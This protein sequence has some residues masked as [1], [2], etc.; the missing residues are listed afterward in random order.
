MSIR[1]LS[2]L[3]LHESR[4]SYNAFCIFGLT[5]DTSSLAL[6]KTWFYPHS[7]HLW[8]DSSSQLNKSNSAGE[9]SW[10]LCAQIL[11][12]CWEVA[13]IVASP[14]NR[15]ILQPPSPW[16]WLDPLIGLGRT[17]WISTKT[18]NL[19]LKL[20]L[21]VLIYCRKVKKPLCDLAQVSGTAVAVPCF[22]W[23]PACCSQSVLVAD[24]HFWWVPLF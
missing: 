5:E 1:R 4:F 22:C 13:K 6:G 18:Q 14:W 19:H 9:L 16:L 24:N 12:D 7:S 21:N 2:V 23:V 20:H 10:G 15:Q 3:F 8:A 17:S 11:L